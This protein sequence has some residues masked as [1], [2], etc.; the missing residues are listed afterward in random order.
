MVV[1]PGSVVTLTAVADPGFHF[2]GWGGDT[3]TLTNTISL[4]VPVDRNLTAR[5][6][7]NLYTLT[8]DAEG[9]GTATSVPSLSS[10]P[11]GASVELRAMPDAGWRFVGWREGQGD[12]IVRRGGPTGGPGCPDCALGTANP[13]AIEMLADRSITAVFEVSGGGLVVD[14]DGSGVV[15]EELVPGSG[16]TE[17]EA[18]AEPGWRFLGWSGDFQGGEPTL[19]IPPGQTGRVVATFV[20]EGEEPMRKAVSPLATIAPPN[21]LAITRVAPNP[22][23]GAVQIDYAAPRDGHVRIAVIDAQGREIARVVD[24]WVS[25]GRYQAAWN[26]TGV[27]GRVPAG[28]YFVRLTSLEKTLVRRLVIAR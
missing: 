1:T 20:Q 21:E 7:N 11:E 26:G 2:A 15:L 28:V 13:L 24:R 12:R 22:S 5:F 4:A 18:I 27:R 19:V 16:A 8:L 3:T 25:P 10:Y 6:T 17:L 9:G 14:T 23:A